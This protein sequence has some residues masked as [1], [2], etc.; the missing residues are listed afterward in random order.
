MSDQGRAY[1][2]A[3]SPYRGAQFAIHLALGDVANDLHGHRL[4]MK[5]STLAWKA[6]T[7][8]QTVV[9]AL[10][11]MVADGFLERLSPETRQG[12]P[13]EYRFLMPAVAI[14][15][16]PEVSAEV[17]PDVSAH[18]TPVSATATPRVSPGD[19][20]PK[21][22]RTETEGVSIISF[23]SFWNHYPRKVGK[24]SARKA[25]D[26]AVRVGADP[27]QIITAVIAYAGDTKRQQADISFTAHPAT[28]LN[29]ERWLDEAD[30]GPDTRPHEDIWKELAG[31]R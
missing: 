22:N 1:V 13:V 10:A 7:T 16:A 24:G 28:W 11:R 4:W 27:G 12:R 8:R 9:G 3:Y 2:Y 25:W 31:D 15:F 23:E 21:K 5:A 6:R 14:Q 20:E 18:V 30:P 17:T 29:A 26:K 19:T